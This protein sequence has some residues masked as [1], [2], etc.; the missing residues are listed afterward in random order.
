MS[1]S[2]RTPVERTVTV[3]AGATA[4]V[5]ASGGRPMGRRR[6]G[7]ALGERR[8]PCAYELRRRV[9]QYPGAL[10]CSRRRARIS[11]LSRLIV[12]KEQ[13]FPDIAYG[14]RG[15][16]PASREGC[17]DAHGQ[18]FHTSYWGH[19][20][21]LGRRSDHLLLPGY[22]GYPNTAARASRPTNAD[23]ADMAHA[24]GALVGYVH[25]F[26]E[27]AEPARQNRSTLDQTSFRSMSRLEKSTT[28][29]SCGF[30]D[31]RSTA[32][33]W[34]RLLNLGFRLPAAG[35]TDAMAE[36]CLPARTRSG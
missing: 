18:E 13:R 14:G 23:V 26:E 8:C 15:V 2:R 27:A 35:G 4:S 1:G 10:C 32:S 29:K 16:D 31:H 7:R 11:I 20:G 9:P 12:N 36:F 25:P 6:P 24:R 21:M 5:A 30:C 22:G 33:V 28:S 19:L 3:T 34:Y 17:A